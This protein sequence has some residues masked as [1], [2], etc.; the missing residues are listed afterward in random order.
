MRNPWAFSVSRGHGGG[1]SDWMMCAIVELSVRSRRSAPPPAVVG[2]LAVAAKERGR[3][4]EDASRDASV[5]L[6]GKVDEPGAEVWDG[7]HDGASA[8]V[9]LPPEGLPAPLGLP[10][11]RRAIAWL[12]ANRET[13]RR[14]STPS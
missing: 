14:S 2:I 12:A 7:G 11:L 1:R 6:D 9:P 3:R 13:A 5:G 8:R 10:F 4:R